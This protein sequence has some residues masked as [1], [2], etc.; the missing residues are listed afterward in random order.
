MLI[1]GKQ[2]MV[3]GRIVGIE[4]F[5]FGGFDGGQ[6][7]LGLGLRSHLLRQV[8]MKS[9]YAVSFSF[10]T[11]PFL[12]WLVAWKQPLNHFSVINQW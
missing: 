10:L 6:T 12:T 2:L 5:N 3:G 11:S 9:S 8:L 1:I 7:P 4:M